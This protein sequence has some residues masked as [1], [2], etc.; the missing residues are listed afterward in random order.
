MSPSHS[1]DPH[2]A[3]S[4][5]WPSVDA[6]GPGNAAQ[7][8]RILRHHARGGL[9]EVFVARDE[10]LHREVALKEI[11]PQH[12]DQPESRAR[13]LLEAEITGGLE[14]PGIV[15]VYGF[16]LYPDGRPFYA[17][18]FIKGD[19]LKDAIDRFHHADAV[20]RDQ[21]EREESIQEYHHAIRLDPKFAQ[22]HFNLGF[23]LAA[24][25]QFDEAIQHFQQAASLGLVSA[26]E[27]ARRCERL[28]ELKH[29]LPA[30]LDGKDRPADAQEML[31]FADLCYQ[32]FLK[33]YAAAACF[34]ADA[35]AADARL[36][37]DTKAQHR[38]NAAC[39]AALAGCGQGNDAA[40]LDDKEKAHLRRQ[41]LDWLKADLTHW[42]NLARS[43]KADDRTLA[44]QVLE[45]WQED[46]DLAGVR[47]DALAK[48]PESER[49]AWKKLWADVAAALVKTR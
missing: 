42:T 14:H 19:S 38:Y 48:L 39:C 10:E 1:N 45:H 16:G 32:P 35:F 12:A 28:R 17:M 5:C 9:G 7:R 33:R 25:G 4:P 31:A 37:D 43:S 18:R 11:Q 24:T 6:A 15:P 13:F 3:G 44:R 49:D 47:G 23:V 40:H 26:T 27:Q 46:S 29:R 36:A 41:A 2:A 22:P 30:V 34:L 8:Y 21:G 20:P